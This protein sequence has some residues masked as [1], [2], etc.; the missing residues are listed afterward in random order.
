MLKLIPH[1][2]FNGNCIEALNFYLNIFNGE[3]ELLDKYKDQPELT[4]DQIANQVMLAHMK[5]KNGEFYASDW[6]NSSKPPKQI[7][8]IQF[9][10]VK[11]LNT[12]LYKLNKNKTTEVQQTVFGDLS[13]EITDPYS[14]T[15]KLY[16]LN[17]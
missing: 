17:S 8:W 6:I 1:L 3:I 13:Y 16:C 11:E 14:I 10:S 9:D 15:W 2:F 4:D 5:F 12:L 7:I